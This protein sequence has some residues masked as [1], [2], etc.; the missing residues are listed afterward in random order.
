MCIRNHPIRSYTQI[1]CA[2]SQ[3]EAVQTLM[4]KCGKFKDRVVI[5]HTEVITEPVVVGVYANND[6]GRGTI[7]V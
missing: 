7:Y 6:K 4:E 1:V 5:M 3:R 2:N